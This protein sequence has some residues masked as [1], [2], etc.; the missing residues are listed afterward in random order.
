MGLAM[1]TFFAE[2]GLGMYPTL[3]FG[4]LL[5]AVAIAYAWRPARRL[6]ALYSVLGVVELA[7]GVLGLT[8]GIVTTLLYTSKLPPES[9]Y[10]VTLL[11][12]AESLHNLVLSLAMLVLATLVLAGGILRAALR[13]D[14]DR[15]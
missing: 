6:L 8:L 2:G 3:A 15:S 9:Q 12:L 13:P 7:C 10:A 11:G 5:V 4:L 14:A 1:L